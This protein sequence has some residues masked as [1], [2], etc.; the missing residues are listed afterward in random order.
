MSSRSQPSKKRKTRSGCSGIELAGALHALQA[1]RDKLKV[2]EAV[3]PDDRQ[4]EDVGA[5]IEIDDTELARFD[6]I[7]EWMKS[8]TLTAEKVCPV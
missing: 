3:E 4:V 1:F 7:I 8:E 5:E 2:H 6:G